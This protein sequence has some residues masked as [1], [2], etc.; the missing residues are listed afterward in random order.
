VSTVLLSDISPEEMSASRLM[1]KIRPFL[2]IP[3]NNVEE[4]RKTAR[5]NKVKEQRNRKCKQPYYCRSTS[6]ENAKKEVSKLT[7]DIIKRHLKT[8]N[9]CCECWENYM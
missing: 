6:L 4:K 2:K 1:K 8:E 7:A 5:G 9:K 3:R